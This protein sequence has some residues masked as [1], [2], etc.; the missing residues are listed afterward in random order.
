MVAGVTASIAVSIKSQLVGVGDL[1]TPR[2]PVNLDALLQLTGG[3]DAT[4]KAN[5]LFADNR[6]LAASATENLDLA[7]ALADALGATFTA[8]EVVAIYVRAVAANTNSVVVFGAASNAFNGPLSGT[9][10]KL[11]LTLAPG[12]FALLTCKNGW[13]VTAGTGDLILVA[14]SGAGTPV[15]YDI[16]II[17]RTAAA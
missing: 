11:T 7:G 5:I 2:A 12:D 6:T 13:A 3:T 14:N 4:S 10:P 9:T 17:G 15:S 16:V 8:A 1:G